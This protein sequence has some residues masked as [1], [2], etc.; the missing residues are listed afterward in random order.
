MEDDVQTVMTQCELW[1]DN[2]D[3]IENRHRNVEDLDKRVQA[4]AGRM[5][6]YV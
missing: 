5:R 1:T 4:Y 2:N 3:N 6:E